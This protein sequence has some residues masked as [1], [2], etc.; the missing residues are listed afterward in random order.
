MIRSMWLCRKPKRK[1]ALRLN[2]VRD[3][4]IP[5]GVEFEIFEPRAEREVDNGTVTRA[6]ATCLCC[7][8]VLPPERV[9]AQL[10]AQR[11]GAD[12]VFGEQGNRTGGAK[13]TAVVILKPGQ[14]GRHYRLPTDADYEAVRLAQERVEEYP[15]RMGGWKAGRDCALCQ[16]SQRP[17]VEVLELGERSVSND[18]GCSSGATCSRPGRRRRW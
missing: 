11:G 18:M 5:P 6:R 8:A 15:G 9:R 17:Q 2:V 14:Q 3:K 7:Q 1:W 12:T 16:T 13:M 10:A 4:G